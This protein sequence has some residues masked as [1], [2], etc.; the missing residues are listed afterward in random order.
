MKWKLQNNRKENGNENR[1]EKK[2][3]K[4]KQKEKEILEIWN[5]MANFIKQIKDEVHSMQVLSF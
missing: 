4:E 1:R 3:F 5:F 2:M